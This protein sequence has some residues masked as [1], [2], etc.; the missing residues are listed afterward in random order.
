MQQIYLPKVIFPIIL[1]LKDTVKFLFILFLLLIFLWIYG[2]TIGIAYLAL[3]VVLIIQLLFTTALVFFLAAI[4]PFLPDL[5][6]VVEN[7]L[8]ALFFMSG[9]MVRS[10]VIPEVYKSFY[11]LNPIV[12][13][14]ESYRNILMYNIWPDGSTLFIITIGSLIGIWLSATI[15]KKFEYIYPKI[16]S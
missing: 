15:I 3:P 10:D 2:Y 9:V 13:I 14:I 11:Y 1:I 16:M 7:I 6:F 4:I 5:R 12:T 8:L